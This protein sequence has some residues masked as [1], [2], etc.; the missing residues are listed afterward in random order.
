MKWIPNKTFPH[1]VLSDGNIPAM[2]RD[3]VQRCFQP[4][5]TM[6]LK[7][8][9]V[10]LDVSFK[11]SEQSLLELVGQ[12]K[13]KY[14][15]EIHCRE[16]FLRRTMAEQGNHITHVFKKGDLQG[17]V[18]IS[19]Y[20]VATAEIRGH[21]SETIHGEFGSNSSFDF[22][23]GAVLAIAEP[24]T[25]WF[26]MDPVRA[27][28]SIIDLVP[29]ANHGNDFFVELSNDKIQII[30]N[31]DDAK[32]FSSMEKNKNQQSIALS[33]VCFPAFLEA[34]HVMRTDKDGD[35]EDRRWYCV[36]KQEL[37]NKNIDLDENSNLLEIAQQLLNSPVHCM[38]AREETVQ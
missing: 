24:A 34:L 20:L 21:T 9:E 28:S 19:F 3:Y 38:M 26:D 11:M 27:I 17:R 1:P 37:A 13:A 12:C 32:Y 10:K 29:K 2:E 36:I 15:V 14:V 8:G 33:A 18:D 25:Y 31:K 16:T 22:S 6:T 30:M 5:D 7:G 4:T 23:P 35:L